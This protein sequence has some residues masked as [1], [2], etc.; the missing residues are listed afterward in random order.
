ME[1]GQAESGQP[2]SQPPSRPLSIQQQYSRLAKIDESGEVLIQL[3]NESGDKKQSTD[4]ESI[5][6]LNESPPPKPPRPQF[7]SSSPPLSE[8]GEEVDGVRRRPLPR[9]QHNLPSADDPPVTT[10][11][12]PPPL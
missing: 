8:T 9:Q 7:P 3:L 12:P 2:S 5:F 4:T 11:E 1:P 6:Y 10:K